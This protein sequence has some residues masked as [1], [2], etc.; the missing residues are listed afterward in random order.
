MVEYSI[1]FDEKM[2]RLTFFNIRSVAK[3][4]TTQTR[5]SFG[6]LTRFEKKS[7]IVKNID[8]GTGP[9]IV[10][11]NNPVV[12]GNN[13]LLTLMGEKLLL[14]ETYPRFH[15]TMFL[16]EVFLLVLVFFYS[17]EIF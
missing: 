12:P 3:Y 14:N 16:R 4:R 5:D 9:S 11:K 13:Y 8:P 2:D 10:S 6:N 1:P 15:L 17:I 7:L